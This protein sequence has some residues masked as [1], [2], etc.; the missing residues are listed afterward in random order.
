VSELITRLSEIQDQQGLSNEAF[1]RLLGVDRVTWSLT[2]RGKRPLGKRVID[3]ALRL[4]PELSYV[5]AQ[6]LQDSTA[7]RADVDGVAV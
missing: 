1:S 6:S 3:G 5:Y 7:T 2:R 4:R